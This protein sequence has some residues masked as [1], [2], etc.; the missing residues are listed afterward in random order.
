MTLKQFQSFLDFLK[1]KGYFVI[2]PQKT[3][4]KEKEEAVVM[5]EL[6]DVNGF[7]VVNELPFYPFK[8][9][10]IPPQEVLFDYDKNN[11]KEVKNNNNLQALVG[12]TLPD[13]RAYTLWN[14]VFDKDPYYQ[15]RKKNTLVIGHSV[16]PDDKFAFYLEQFE[17]NIL[18][19]LNFDIFLGVEGQEFKVFTGSE[20]GQK[21]L[22]GFGFGDYQHIEFAGPVKEEGIDQE[23][24]L[25]R[26]KMKNHHNQKIW[27]DLGK[28]CIECGKCVIVCPTC[29]CFDLSDSPSSKDG[30]GQR[31]RC[32]SSCFYS[33]FSQVM[34]G[35][36]FLNSPA[37]RIHFWYEHKFVRIPDKFSVM[38]CV[39]CG[40]CSRA[41]PADI[42]IHKVLEDIKKI[43]PPAGGKKS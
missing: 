39:G 10:L 33:E 32:W 18:E 42:Q 20:E 19:H 22:D 21:M 31:L 13:L 2:A 11:F 41:C 26:D 16:L 8:N 7:E 9:F 6:D 37:E 34:G 4:S 30:E 17:E 3:G 29:F 12:I 27:N 5:K 1:Q 15:A 43:N 35:Y 28:R 38:G 40:R 14:Q 24:A 23:T 25:I 36:R